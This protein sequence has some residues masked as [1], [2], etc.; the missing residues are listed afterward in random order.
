MEK[1]LKFTKLMC[2]INSRIMSVRFRD[3]GRPLSHSHNENVIPFNYDMRSYEE[4]IKMNR[5]L[6]SA[7]SAL[8]A[9]T[10][11]L[12]LGTA[13][14]FAVGTGEQ[15]QPVVCTGSA[16]VTD[17]AAETH[18][19]GCPKYVSAKTPAEGAEEK[20]QPAVCTGS[21][22]AAEC[23]AETHVEG[24]PKYVS[25][26]AAGEGE[27]SE[28]DAQKAA[29]QA[30]IEALPGKD[31]FDAMSE[32]D[33]NGVAVEYAAIMEELYKL[34]E[35]EGI[36]DGDIEKLEGI[37]L[38]KLIALS[39]AI[40]EYTT[41][42]LTDPAAWIGTTGYETLKEAVS[43]AVSGD[44]ITLGEGNYTLYGIS[45]EGTTKG[46]SLTFVGQGADK[47][48]WNIG[49]EVPDPAN[50]GTEYNG[51]YSLD[52]AGTVTFRNMT[53]RSGSA[54]Y[55]GF[56]RADKT[57][58]DGCVI[59]GKTFYW[60]YTSATFTNTTFNCPQG[61]YAL[62]TYSSPVMTFDGCRFNA[63]GKVINVY[64]DYGAGKNDITVNFN[65]CTVN[66]SASNKSALNINDSNMGGFKYNINITT[67]PGAVSGLN[68]SNITCSRV[69]GFSS[70][71]NN[72][73]RSVVSINN[74]TVWT[75]GKMVSHAMDC[76]SVKYTDGYNDN[77]FD[78]TYSDWVE[79]DTERTRTVKKVCRY[80]G[81]AEEFTETEKKLVLSYDAN[82]GTGV[83]TSDS[84]FGE[85]TV[86]VKANGFERADYDFTG[87]NTA[88][89]GKGTAYKPGAEINMTDSLTLYAQWG[90]IATY[91][92]TYTDGVDNVIIFQDQVYL[93]LKS[94]DKTPGFVGVP[95]RRG[96][97]FVG[98]EPS[99]SQTVTGNAVYKA[100]WER[101]V[102]Y[103]YDPGKGPRTVDESNLALW[104]LLM[105]GAGAA[106]AGAGLCVRKRRRSK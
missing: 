60:G 22:E 75:D 64:T 65:N 18:I 99:V 36:E 10:M 41:A 20:E 3:K 82:G 94:G 37:D 12:S 102:I 63:S 78:I 16:E 83:M 93:G 13:A 19:E 27:S 86:T 96:Y 5:K 21:A 29:V 28:A 103:N 50:Y 68:P 7:L 30:R 89:D 54:D 44:T 79:T 67:T 9:I 88:A 45:S 101:I 87:W 97:R 6:K 43:A 72:T 81:Y 55:L 95:E 57:I 76:G 53:L 26:D 69:F 100:V 47:T 74:T 77:A 80:C 85:G 106:A 84:R 8:L 11:M 42:P 66:S 14:A 61:D 92:V 91:T 104:T 23:A 2:I 56:I 70:A 52:G 62:W 49:A 33:K 34:C 25:T 35:A 73:G 105:L 15:G 90:K 1:G 31:A 17:C 71:V 24:C 98:W 39:D 51:D 48:A 58:V 59:N 40:N 38:G 32:E 46:K 4:G